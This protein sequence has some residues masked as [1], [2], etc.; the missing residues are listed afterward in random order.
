[1]AIERDKL[2]Q[3]IEITTGNS[4][5]EIKSLTKSIKGLSDEVSEV[6]IKQLTKDIENLEKSMDL[7]IDAANKQLADLNKTLKL[8]N[9]TTADSASSV[10]KLTGAFA[11]LS[12]F[13]AT[14]DSLINIVNSFRNALELLSDPKRIRR[15]ATLIN[16]MGSLAII[17]GFGTQGEA[18]KKFSN[19]LQKAA[20]TLEKFQVKSLDDRL[21]GLDSTLDGIA[22]ALRTVKTTAETATVGLLGLGGVSVA[23]GLSPQFKLITDVI[24]SDLSE[25]IRKSSL[26]FGGL[27]QAAR[28]SG[29]TFKAVFSAA[30]KPA[31]PGLIGLTEEMSKVGIV[32]AITGRKLEES[33]NA[34]ISFT[35]T[36]TK[37][38]GV[39]LGGLSFAISLVVTSIGVLIQSVSIEL[40]NALDGLSKKFEAGQAKV[41]QFAFIVKGF[42][43]VF[44]EEV[45]GTLAQWGKLIGDVTEN[46]VTAASEV[47]KAIGSLIKEAQILGLTSK[48]IE[49]VVTRAN[50][51]AAATGQNLSEVVG[52]LISGFVGQSQAALNLGVDLRELTVAHGQLEH[53]VETLSGVTDSHTKVQL[54]MNEFFS[55]TAPIV[56]AAA[57]AM[58]SL[59]GSEI[60][61]SR[62]LGNLSTRIGGSATILILFNKALSGVLSIVNKLPDSFFNTVGAMLQIASVGGIILGTFLKWASII[63]L[64]IS[65]F[66]ILNALIISSTTAQTV[67]TTVM[68][69]MGFSAGVTTGSITS[70]NVALATFGTIVK[71][72]LLTTIGSLGTSLVGLAAFIAKAFLMASKALGTFLVAFGP[73]IIKIT[74]VIAAFVLINK[75]IDAFRDILGPTG[76]MLLDF[77]VTIA[78]LAAAIFAL[79]VVIIK[80]AVAQTVLT[81]AVARL[82]ATVGVQAVAVTSLGTLWTAASGIFAGAAATL[83]AGLV[84][85]ITSAVLAL[86]AF[87]VAAAAAV[88]PFIPVIAVVAGAVAVLAL[89]IN[90]TDAVAD[91]MGELTSAFTAGFSPMSSLFGEMSSG[92][93]D[94]G[95]LESAFDLLV[96]TIGRVVRTVASL[97]KVLVSGVA[98]GILFVNKSL[99]KFRLLLADDGKE[100]EQLTAALDDNAKAFDQLGKSLIVASVG[101]ASFGNESD[102]A[103]AKVNQ[104]GQEAVDLKK[105]IDNLDS[106]VVLDSFEKAV[107]DI[108]ELEEE[109]DRLGKS[110]VQNIIDKE[111]AQQGLLQKVSAELGLTK[112]LTGERL[113]QLQLKSDLLSEKKAKE[114]SLLRL[115]VLKDISAENSRMSDELELSGLRGKEL[116]DAQVAIELRK[117]ELKEFQLE[118]DG[119]LSEAA[120]IQLN[121]QKE[122]VKQLGIAGRKSGGTKSA[123]KD[124]RIAAAKQLSDMNINLAN[125][126]KLIGLEGIAL[127]REQL[128]IELA[129][130]DAKELQLTKDKAISAEAIASLNEQRTLLTEKFELEGRQRVIDKMKEQAQA[131]QEIAN[132][133]TEVSNQL[134]IIGMKGKALADAQL[135]IEQKK[136]VA[137]ESQLKADGLFSAQAE[138]NLQKQSDLLGQLA[139]KN[140]YQGQTDALDSILSRTKEIE[141]QQTLSGLRGTAL[142]EE[143]S[144]IE[145]QAI[146][147]KQRELE[148]AGLLENEQGEKVRKAL[149][150]Q[151]ALVKEIGDERVKSASEPNVIGK[152]LS[153]GLDEAFGAGAATIATGIGG[154]VAAFSNPVGLMMSA[155]DAIGG[156]IKQLLQFIPK[157]FNMVADIL[158]MITNLPEEILLAIKNLFGAILTLITEG[159]KNFLQFLPQLFKDMIKFAFRDLPI[160][161]LQALKD[162]PQVFVDILEKDLPEIIVSLIDGLIA[163]GPEIAIALAEGLIDA[164][165]KIATALA[166]AASVTI[167]KAIIEGLK[168][169]FGRLFKGVKV[170]SIKLPDIGPFIKQVDKV[171]DKA[172]KGAAKVADE[173][174]SLIDI[175]AAGGDPSK[176]AGEKI[177][178]LIT[179]AGDFIKSILDQ[180]LALLKKVWLWVWNKILKPIIDLVKK[181]WLWVWKKVIKPIVDIVKKAWL[182][183]FDKLKMV[184]KAAF[185]FV[186]DLWAAFGN[187]VKRAWQF[188]ID[189]FN[190]LGNIITEA[191]STIIAYFNAFGSIISDAWRTV[192]EVFGRLGNIV[193]EAWATIVNFFS[194]IF[195][196]KVKEAFLVVITFFRDL[197]GKL[198]N[199][200]MPVIEFFKRTL[201]TIMGFFQNNLVPLFE[202]MVQPFILAIQAFGEILALWVQPLVNLFNN[203]NTIVADAFAPVFTFFLS[204]LKGAVELA[205]DSLINYFKDVLP[206]V[207]KTAWAFLVTYFKDVLPGVIKAAWAFLVTY[208]KDVLPGVIK[209]AWGFVTNFFKS[210]LKGDIKGAFRSVFTFFRDLRRPFKSLIDG[211]KG[212]KSP[213]VKL[214]S[215]FRSVIGPFKA[216]ADALRNPGKIGGG[217]GNQIGG[218]T[219]QV[220]EGV[221]GGL[222]SAGLG[223]AGEQEGGTAGFARSAIAISQVARAQLEKDFQIARQKLR[224]ISGASDVIANSLEGK[225]EVIEQVK[226]LE[227][228]QAFEKTGILTFGGDV[229]T[230]FRNLKDLDTFQHGGLVGDGGGLVETPGEFVLSRPSVE[231]IGVGNAEFINRTGRLPGGGTEITNVM[232][233]SDGAIIVNQMEGTP[234]E[235]ANKLIEEIKRRTL[236]GE[237]IISAEG[238]RA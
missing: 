32:L 52:A 157:M 113:K 84:P 121:A 80:S 37:I 166:K 112:Q 86:K 31:I 29:N 237:F 110:Q 95:L 228:E 117:L 141:Q 68:A 93:Q 203:L 21:K 71:T 199:A 184:V 44:G 40:F 67:L 144:R 39:A 50:D 46:S 191:W 20:D 15:L 224:D 212:F 70:L 62:E 236:D 49:E 105:K 147:D 156:A 204:S 96:T 238:V 194:L 90:A 25:A 190:A 5:K 126:N 182:F 11:G 158:N 149:E 10:S 177:E 154:A 210:V 235:T 218:T 30:I 38:V 111:N 213:V 87:I 114:L 24:G 26:A 164:M 77:T 127:A 193:K 34:F 185:K 232:N 207:I 41:A 89:L 196:G 140:L 162:L 188:I 56:G 217:K 116:A 6:K 174:F 133:N 59:T 227:S 115:D 57:L 145:I 23:R 128:R 189:F 99:L 173:V 211:L 47:R 150:D 102:M 201:A 234:E 139:D 151:L 9:K 48:Q 33:E 167:P 183:V 163:G 192:L 36:V 131:A 94:V 138:S 61:V 148:K 2:I 178:E 45:A 79:N 118:K 206:G 51:V 75:A 160:A 107:E 223:L 221:K 200:F 72:Q 142:A 195:Q 7:E 169:A 229:A 125:Q 165:P 103:A 233:I 172:S 101:L 8:L 54:R 28:S 69:A 17:K 53:G 179:I 216:L 155:A 14:L 83:S 13:L 122:L 100:T 231:G 175:P 74:A 12:S 225:R 119:L 97:A 215:A 63:S 171:I 135:A 1:M 136:L 176:G 187:I 3:E 43:K 88:A 73:L 91:E 230:G 81:G 197:G 123:K 109:I 220:A 106:D 76:K 146:N 209:A 143:R 4:S 55:Q 104:F 92:A 58:D 65:V 132:R 186:E 35:G 82:S 22:G 208:L 205:W 16:I 198:A 27:S 60:R 78:L 42:G 219:G 130:V 222:K 202:A 159:L 98:A 18:L 66:T 120:I 180:F 153:S 170:P 181:A 64:L 161:L 85:A 226:R 19:G 152:S 124:P 214:A 129:K 137:K 134:I 108:K 168:K